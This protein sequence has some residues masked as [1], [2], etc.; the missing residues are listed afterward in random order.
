MKK[1]IDKAIEVERNRKKTEAGIDPLAS[2]IR[3]GELKQLKD[4]KKLSIDDPTY[5]PNISLFQRNFLRENNIR[6]ISKSTHA[7]NV[8]LQQF[9][10]AKG[11][12]EPS[13]Y[14]LIDEFPVKKLT[15]QEKEA[16]IKSYE[17]LM[18][19]FFSDV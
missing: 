9:A 14:I 6:L 2:N 7:D 19:D 12:S 11:K 13:E 17:Q 10:K 18:K 16:A 3:I 8:S 1:K 15:P 5:F 4:Y